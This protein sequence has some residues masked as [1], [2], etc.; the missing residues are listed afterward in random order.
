VHIKVHFEV[1]DSDISK[2]RNK[3][4]QLFLETDCTDMLMT[5]CDLGFDVDAILKILRPE[6]KVCMGV[7]PYRDGTGNYPVQIKFDEKGRPNFKDNLIELD[8]GP[9]G[10]IRIERSVI[11]DLINNHPEWKTSL[12]TP[13]GNCIHAIFDSGMLRGDGKWYSE[14]FMFCF[15]WRDMGG[16][17]W[18]DP[19]ITFEHIGKTAVQGMFAQ[20]ISNELDK[21]DAEMNARQ[22][23]QQDAKEQPC[24]A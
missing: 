23:Q 11:E 5:D 20:F 21:L 8:R 2:A 13:S 24:L 15:R 18:A 7:Y 9:T 3:I 19:T 12:T 17:I 22:K 10:L 4:T 14:D 6:A 1:G 16:R